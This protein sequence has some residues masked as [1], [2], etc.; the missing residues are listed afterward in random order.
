MITFS[1]FL[2]PSKNVKWCHIFREI[3]KERKKESR[4][5]SSYNKEKLP[6][7]QLEKKVSESDMNKNKYIVYLL[8]SFST[9]T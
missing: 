3:K 4:I 9:F 7:K 1:S 5:S 2:S 8:G 6:S